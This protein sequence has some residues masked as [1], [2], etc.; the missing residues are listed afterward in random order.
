MKRMTLISVVIMLGLFLSPMAQ[1]KSPVVNPGTYCTNEDLSDSCNDNLF[2]TK[3]WKEKF[4]GGGP[5]EPGNTLMAIGKGFVFQNAVLVEGPSP[6]D[7]LPDWCQGLGGVVAYET[8][9]EGGM[10]TLNPSGPWRKNFK[11]KD[12]TATNTSC[13]DANGNLLGFRLAM[14]GAFDRPPYCFSIDASFNV[15]PDNYK[16]K[17]DS[18]RVVFQI[19]YDFDAL[20]DIH[21]CE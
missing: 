2:F 13:H 10:L 8:P 1:A 20:I 11:A 5:G 15:T 19:G 3:F 14:D 12:V 17:R 18:D 4:F 21:V 9:Y 6:V 16:V 7:G